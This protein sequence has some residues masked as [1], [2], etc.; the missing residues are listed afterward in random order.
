MTLDLTGI[1]DLSA[2]L[3]GNGLQLSTNIGA[4]AAKIP[5]QNGTHIWRPPERSGQKAPSSQLDLAQ[6]PV[7]RAP[8]R[9][10]ILGYP[11]SPDLGPLSGLAAQVGDPGM[12][13]PGQIWGRS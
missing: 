5:S 2:G 11:G 6:T 7:R 13:V 9:D 3:L 4:C 10:P 1:T 8:K 12:A